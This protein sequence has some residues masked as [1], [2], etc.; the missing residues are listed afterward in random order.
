M[1]LSM[2]VP[3]P[4]PLGPATT[5]ATG[6]GSRLLCCLVFSHSSRLNREISTQVLSYQPENS[7]N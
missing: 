6:S 4:T 5:T 2:S 7:L 1:S 3:F